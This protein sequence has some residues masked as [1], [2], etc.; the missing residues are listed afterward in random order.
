MTINKHDIVKVEYTGYYDDGTVFETTEEL[1]SPMI[2][3]VGSQTLLQGF[4]DALIG[5]EVGEI[6]TVRIPASEAFGRR[7][8]ELVQT[9]AREDFPHGEEEPKPGMRLKLMNANGL[10]NSDV[11]VKEVTENTVTLDLN[12]PSAGKALNFKI[13]IVEKG[14]D[15]TPHFTRNQSIFGLNCDGSCS[16]PQHDHNNDHNQ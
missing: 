2:F 16:T 9:I 1:G 5:H 10:N 12:H 8:S 13:K 6:V 11:W 15:L 4:E 14:E 3:E 7:H